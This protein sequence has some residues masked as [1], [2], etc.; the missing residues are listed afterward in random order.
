[1]VTHSRDCAV[2]G[3]ERETVRLTRGRFLVLAAG[4]QPRPRVNQRRASDVSPVD[5]TTLACAVT[6]T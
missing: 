4:P 3:H 6:P 1:M 5:V 2:P